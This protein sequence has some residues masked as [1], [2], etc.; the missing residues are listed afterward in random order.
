[1]NDSLIPLDSPLRSIPQSVDHRTILYLDG[2]RYSI[3]ITELAYQ[4]LVRILEEY[5][6][7]EEDA[8]QVNRRIV[9]AMSD[10]WML[11]DSVHRL[12]ELVQQTPR[13]K[14]NEPN[15]QLFLR[16]TQKVE[17]LRNFIQH[18]RTGI[19][20]FVVR[21]M[22]VWGT[23][24]WGEINRDDG[25]LINHILIPGTFYEG[26]WAAGL[27]ID[28]RDLSFR[29]RLVLSAGQ[30]QID[31]ADLFDY[32]AAFAAWYKTWFEATFTDEPRH[33]ADTH[34]QLTLRE[35]TDQS[36]HLSNDNSDEG[37]NYG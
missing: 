28:G 6:T 37:A 24:A 7:T 31:L 35:V 12:R 5:R 30:Y 32:V 25:S 36:T 27:T 2:I 22:S 20:E 15:L 23:L 4:R 16:R 26:V 21:N 10:A 34:L 1:M 11:I 17:E 29:E 19:N 14:K 18:L 3:E 13:L 8:P 33:G 9:Q